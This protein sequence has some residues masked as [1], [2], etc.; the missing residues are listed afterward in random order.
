MTRRGAALSVADSIFCSF[1]S[2]TSLAE[3][4]Q[5]VSAT[6][7]WLDGVDRVLAG[8]PLSPFKNHV[9][10]WARLAEEAAENFG[11]D[12]PAMRDIASCIV[13]TEVVNSQFNGAA[14]DNTKSLLTAHGAESV[15]SGDVLIFEVLQ[16]VK[17]PTCFKTFE[18]YESV[19]HLRRHMSKRDD[20]FAA[21]V[22]PWRAAVNR[23]RQINT[24]LVIALN[25]S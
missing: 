12:H 17:S 19:E 22:M 15:L 6:T 8:N 16:S 14:M 20:A 4:S 1:E 9:S 23:V 3:S 2:F 25:E 10:E 21:S 18:L 11:A 13:A 7:A 5:G 24:P